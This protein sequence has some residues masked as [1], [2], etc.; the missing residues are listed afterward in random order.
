MAEPL[1]YQIRPIEPGDATEWNSLRTALWPD[2]A[3]DHPEEIAAFFAGTIAE[4]DAV[5][6]AI[7]PDG[8]WLGFSEI[9]IRT[10]LTETA[11]KKTGYIEGLYVIPEA[12]FRGVG[13][14]LT[15][16]SCTWAREQHCTAFASDR[17]GR[18]VVD[19]GY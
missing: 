11:H 19:L 12:R 2:G 14:A 3:A 13:R 8:T 9:S 10:D 15:Q 17:A 5:L 7:T 4:P 18:I 1:A 6:V 16:A